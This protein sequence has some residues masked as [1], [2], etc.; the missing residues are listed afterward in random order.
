MHSKWAARKEQTID[1]QDTH[2]NRLMS[3]PTTWANSLHI[4]L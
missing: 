1:T 4:Y 2:K 3:N